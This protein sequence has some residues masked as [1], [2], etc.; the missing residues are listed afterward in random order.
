MERLSDGAA[1]SAARGTLLASLV[2]AARSLAGSQPGVPVPSRNL[3]ALTETLRV[4]AWLAVRVSTSDALPAP[5]YA[6]PASLPEHTADDPRTR[7]PAVPVPVDVA[8]LTSRLA[9]AAQVVASAERAALTAAPESP[10]HVA[11]DPP[12]PLTVLCADPAALAFAIL[13]V[14][15]DAASHVRGGEVVSVRLASRRT[16]DRSSGHSTPDTAAAAAAAGDHVQVTVTASIPSASLTI[17]DEAEDAGT[18]SRKIAAAAAL[19]APAAIGVLSLSSSSS[20]PR[21]EDDETDTFPATREARMTLYATLPPKPH[22]PDLHFRAH[23]EQHISPPMGR[24]TPTPIPGPLSAPLVTTH[25]TDLHTEHEHKVTQPSR[26]IP[27]APGAPLARPARPARRTPVAPTTSAGGGGSVSGVSGTASTDP[28]VVP[29]SPAAPVRQH[30]AEQA[31]ASLR[32]S[33]R[34][35]L[36][37]TPRSGPATPL[38][39]AM[40]YFGPAL[41]AVPG[42]RAGDK[43]AVTPGAGP[44]VPSNT[45]TTTTALATSPADVPEE[46]ARAGLLV[47]D[48]QGRPAGLFFSP[49]HVATD[50]GLSSQPSPSPIDPLLAS[51]PPDAP[52][53]DVT[54]AEPP[55]DPTDPEVTPAEPEREKTLVPPKP[56]N[57]SENASASLAKLAQVDAL[58][59]LDSDMRNVPSLNAAAQTLASLPSTGRGTTSGAELDAGAGASQIHG[60]S[61]PSAAPHMAPEGLSTPQPRLKAKV[62]T[63]AKKPKDKEKKPEDKK[64]KV[65]LPPIKVLLVE[66]NKINVQILTRLLTR[67]Q[68]QFDVAKNGMEAIAK[69]RDGSFHIIFVRRLSPAPLAL[70]L[71]LPSYLWPLLH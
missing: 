44:D 70:P 69:W 71:S 5:I 62:K 11:F 36:L 49:G 56:G 59:A 54:E 15:I 35:T 17:H 18:R 16:P 3:P 43:P 60:A 34:Y 55:H 32:L 21:E 48:P 24:A 37:H 29:A 10:V 2:G 66:D 41:P 28:V 33:P 12:E 27:Q 58:P 53:A 38:R 57:T 61:A 51:H 39:E 30:D 7:P 46:V 4:A 40:D 65:V 6:Y 68:I 9:H 31:S 42:D 19:V 26:A 25:T 13:Y 14:L 45:A 22:R 63:K 20:M 67:N 47:Q 23:T 50:T 8:L 1:G 64:T 52:L